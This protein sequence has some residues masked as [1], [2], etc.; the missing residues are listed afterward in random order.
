MAKIEE[1]IN[2]TNAQLLQKTLKKMKKVN[3]VKLE[4]SVDAVK[5]FEVVMQGFA[6]MESVMKLELILASGRLLLSKSASTL[7]SKILAKLPSVVNLIFVGNFDSWDATLAFVSTITAR[8]KQLKEFHFSHGDP[9]ATV[10]EHKKVCNVISSVYQADRIGLFEYAIFKSAFGSIMLQHEDFVNLFFRRRSTDFLVQLEKLLAPFQ[11]SILQALSGNVT[12]VSAPPAAQ[13]P[14]T[15]AGVFVQPQTSLPGTVGVANM[16][17]QQSAGMPIS[18][19]RHVHRTKG[20]HRRSR[21]SSH[22]RRAHASSGRRREHRSRDRHGHKMQPIIIQNTTPASGFANKDIQEF[23]TNEYRR[24]IDAYQE[25]AQQNRQI[26]EMM[27]KL[28]SRLDGGAA[29][30]QPQPEGLNTFVSSRPSSPFSYSD[31]YSDRSYSYSYDL[32]PTPRAVRRAADAREAVHSDDFDNVQETSI[33]AIFSDLKDEFSQG[34]GSEFRTV[35]QAQLDDE[36]RSVVQSRERWKEL[37][38]SQGFRT[39]PRNDAR[40]SEES[41]EPSELIDLRGISGDL[42][43]QLTALKADPGWIRRIAHIPAIAAERLK[44]LRVLRTGPASLVLSALLDGELVELLLRPA[45]TDEDANAFVTE[46]LWHS[47]PPSPS[48]AVAIGWCDGIEVLLA[49]SSIE[50]LRQTVLLSLRVPSASAV[51]CAVLLA[52]RALLASKTPELAPHKRVQIWY[53]LLDALE[54]LASLRLRRAGVAPSSHGNISPLTIGVSENAQVLLSDLMF[55]RKARAP[56][57]GTDVPV[58]QSSAAQFQTEKYQS[59]EG[60]VHGDE[61]VA[62]FRR[63]LYSLLMLLES[64]LQLPHLEFV[65]RSLRSLLR[66]NARNGFRTFAELLEITELLTLRSNFAPFLGPKVF[67]TLAW[68]TEDKGLLAAEVLGSEPPALGDAA[69]DDQRFIALYPPSSADSLRRCLALSAA[70]LLIDFFGAPD[71]PASC[72]LL[73][74]ARLR[75]RFDRRC[76]EMARLYRGSTAYAEVLSS[77]KKGGAY[78]NKISSFF[79]RRLAPMR[80]MNRYADGL[81]EPPY[82]AIVLF[83]TDSA[84]AR[85]VAEDGFSALRERDPAVDGYYAHGPVFTTSFSRAVMMAKQRVRFLAKAGAAAAAP[86]VLVCVAV[87]GPVLPAKRVHFQRPTPY[88]AG[89]AASYSLVA[90]DTGAAVSS[91]LVDAVVAGLL[92]D[93]MRAGV[94]DELVVF[95]P[96][97]VLPAFRCALRK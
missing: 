26:L 7:A 45:A 29:K 22:Q 75:A 17:F 13:L 96:E 95:E 52:P 6:S 79:L 27:T 42:H 89:F 33:S 8:M 2:S 80:A 20:P 15:T 86:C 64:E 40:A 19:Y 57:S 32:D 53:Q 90:A 3:Q 30:P 94:Y 18:H 28:A 61:A 47:A 37:A 81:P 38:L 84:S 51:A 43:S 39:R 71:L 48:F 12:F 88:T 25:S 56:A 58:L 62:A 74:S 1:P 41:S 31:E 68:R 21:H 87:L 97:G 66:E 77:F 5:D 73:H 59:F 82:F 46:L 9:S 55:G 10:S 78:F 49:N 72:E 35:T 70:S 69:L 24:Q 85:A 44:V 11:Q 4:I 34:T 16:N 67:G 93:G 92:A 54:S 60:A 83:G 50:N 36:I 63:D 76:A 65:Q 14:S 23:M 91:K